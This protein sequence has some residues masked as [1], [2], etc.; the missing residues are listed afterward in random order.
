RTATNESIV[1][2]LK[3]LPRSQYVGYTATPYANA[4]VN[5]DD[6]EDLFPKD[7][8]VSLDRPRGYMG[9]SD[10]F[11]PV[12][13]YSDLAK[14]DFGEPEIAFVRRIDSLRGEDDEDL[15]QALR[16]F[17]LAGALKL[18]RQAKDPQRYNPEHF[19]HHTML[20]HTSSS[21]GQ[22]ASL[23]DQVKELWDQCAFNSPK[24]LTA[25]G[26]LW[27]DDYSKVCAAQ[28]K[29]EIVP[30]AFSALKSHLSEAI[31]RIVGDQH[32]IRVINSDKDEA[33]DF[34][35]GP[36]WKIVIGGNKLSRGY[37]IEGLTISY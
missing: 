29:G 10:F 37:T 35:A 8:I 15:K 26:K 17:V 27:T 23:A 11:D 14:D 5:P 4:L 28:S 31:N 13:D 20:V 32:F 9:V 30:R 12:V 34:S 19:K 2:L 22:H 25:L 1:K 6:P 3:L 16:S 7:F 33:P 21:K 36:I 24:G 18:Y